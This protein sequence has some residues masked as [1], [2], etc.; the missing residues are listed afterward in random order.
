VTR[1]LGDAAL[2]MV[3]GG[4]FR[5]DGGAMHGV[6]PKKLWS[7]LVS[8]D[9]DNRCTYS[10]NCLYVE[11]GGVRALIETGNGDKFSPRLQQLHGIDHDRSV[12]RALR[13]L[14]IEPD[15][16]DLVVM[17]HLHFDHAGG[18]TRRSAAGVEPVFRRARHVVQARE[19]DAAL[20]PH[21]RNRASYLAENIEPLVAAGLLETVD[22]EAEV[23]PGITVLPT[24]GHTPGHQSVLIDGGD[25]ERAL[26][27]GD[28][29]P[30]AVH[31]R[32]P[33]IMGYDLD[34]EATLASKKRLYA[35]AAAERWLLLF[36][37]DRRHGTYL[38]V[39]EAGQP[40]AGE[41]IDL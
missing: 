11:R 23:A 1:R 19:L 22:G 29:V 38:T 32:L 12:E 7:R 33:W 21:E 39:D 10:T 15:S 25:G 20:H 34:V 9:A 14:G 5:L 24:P 36:G 40:A 18:S 35:R 17:T 13:E 37:H 31:V 16:I 26:F 4:D 8:C 30:T 6:V 3:N 2:T 27:L 41:L 28:V